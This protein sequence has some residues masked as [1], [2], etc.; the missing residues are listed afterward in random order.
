MH[1]LFFTMPPRYGFLSFATPDDMIDCLYDTSKGLFLPCQDVKSICQFASELYRRFQC[2]RHIWAINAWKNIQFCW[3]KQQKEVAF[4]LTG[5]GA[6]QMERA[7]RRSMKHP[8]FGQKDINVVKTTCWTGAENTGAHHAA[9]T[10]EDA[11]IHR[12]SSC[13]WQRFVNSRLI[14]KEAKSQKSV[15]QKGKH[16][17]V[18][19]NVYSRKTLEKTKKRSANFENKGLGVVYARGKY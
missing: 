3:K 12:T 9:G 14:V 16:V 2:Y 5:R 6:M 10:K 13:R 4:S 1:D 18:T 11:R 19:T 7:A 17:G 15:F 8:R